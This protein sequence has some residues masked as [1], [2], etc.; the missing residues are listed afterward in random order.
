VKKD[1]IIPGWSSSE[2]NPISLERVLNA[3]REFACAH[4]IHMPC[5]CCFSVEEFNYTLAP[6]LSVLATGDDWRTSESEGNWK[7]QSW[8]ERRGRWI[9]VRNIDTVRFADSLADSPVLPDANPVHVITR[10]FSRTVMGD[11]LATCDFSAMIILRPKY[12]IF[13]FF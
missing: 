2:C 6:A 7:S 5:I 12:S 9:H 13:F 8:W 3:N 4:R 1:K 11:R 10:V